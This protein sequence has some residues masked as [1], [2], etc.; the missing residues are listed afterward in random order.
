MANE[1]PSQ[2]TMS[3]LDPSIPQLPAHDTDPKGLVGACRR[4]LSGAAFW[5]SIPLPLI[6]LTLLVTGVVNTAPLLVGGLVLVNICCAAL[7]HTYSPRE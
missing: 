6:I 1:R 2:L 4:L 7:G 3:T 5:A